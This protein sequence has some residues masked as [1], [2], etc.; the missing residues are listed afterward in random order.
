MPPPPLHAYDNPSRF[1]SSQLTEEGWGLHAG[2]LPMY[3][4]VWTNDKSWVQRVANNFNSSLA[5]LPHLVLRLAPFSSRRSARSLVTG[6]PSMTAS[7]SSS[8][9]L[10]ILLC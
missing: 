10:F 3:S 4:P 7:H 2:R 6:R 5:A 9:F 1:P 8:N